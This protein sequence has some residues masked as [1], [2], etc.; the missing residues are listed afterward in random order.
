MT[1][2]NTFQMTGIFRSESLALKLEYDLIGSI[3][4]RNARV[5]TQIIR[6]DVPVGEEAQAAILRSLLTSEIVMVPPYT[7]A[8]N[9]A[10]NTWYRLAIAGTSV[11]ELTGTLDMFR[12]L[13]P[14]PDIPVRFYQLIPLGNE[15][16]DNVQ[17]SHMRVK[18]DGAGITSWLEG[19]EKLAEVAGRLANKS[20]EE[21]KAAYSQDPPD[22]LEVWIDKDGFVLQTTIKDSVDGTTSET[23]FHFFNFGKQFTIL[24]PAQFVDDT[25]G[26]P[27]ESRI[28]GGIGTAVPIM[29]R[30][31]IRTGQ[32]FTDYNSS[33]PSSGPHWP[34]PAKCGI[35]KIELADEQV[36]HNLE[37]GNVVISYNLPDAEDVQK[38][39]Q[40]IEELLDTDIGSARQV[41]DW[42][43]VR[44]YEKIDP[45]TVAITAW[46]VLDIMRGVDEAG[47]RTFLQVYP[48]NRHSPE[49]LPCSLK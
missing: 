19:E 23:T 15:L 13:F 40:L 32:R 34:E 41:R 33:P 46:G 39:E 45:G 1:S 47:I 6:L 5:T 38:L 37:H 17:T 11:F 35:Y 24:A 22:V 49:R 12:F 29:G 48:G 4:G 25:S 9:E 42:V 21:F 44:P 26:A 16:I 36:I 30:G 2:L 3:S 20:P 28:V 8:V 10:D 18:A 7:Y 43:V 14:H 31:H 27:I